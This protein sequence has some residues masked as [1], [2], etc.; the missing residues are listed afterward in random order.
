MTEQKLNR[1]CFAV[2]CNQSYSVIKES[3][4]EF[5]RKV[6]WIV[7][8]KTFFDIAICYIQARETRCKC[9]LGHKCNYCKSITPGL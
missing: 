5:G 1:M 3:L 7:D 2:C 6:F 8:A 4:N 9:N